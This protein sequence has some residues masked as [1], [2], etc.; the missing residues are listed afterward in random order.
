MTDE[1]LWDRS[2]DAEPDVV[3]LEGLLARYGAKPIAAPAPGSGLEPRI[4]WYAAAA[5]AAAALVVIVTRLAA[6]SDVWK[7]T[8]P[9]GTSRV[10]IGQ[11][12]RTDAVSRARLSSRAVGTVELA[13]NTTLR[14]TEVREGR[15]ILELSVGTIH[16]K[17]ISPPGV[18]VV[19]TPKARAMD[20]GCEYTLEVE[21]DGGGRLHVDAGWVGL[22]RYGWQS[23]VPERASALFDRDGNLM[24]PVF[25][26]APEGFFAAVQRFSLGEPAGEERDAALSR[27]LELARR[28]DA[29]TLLNLFS[30]ASREERLL[31]Y[32]RLS[33][34]VPAPASVPR[35]AM[36]EG[37]RIGATDAWWPPVLEASGVRA[38]KK[39]KKTL[40]PAR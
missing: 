16:A 29:L 9:R 31:V 39:G 23:L 35:A 10:A 19:D 25:D 13:E 14:V 28:R 18:F 3:R 6:P 24:P 27:I 12:V 22:T 1:Y 8:G 37:W 40:S 4:A 32:D 21:P 33:A 7:V 11:S 36:E 30:R 20:L 26:D 2:G 38:I 5:L 34:L 17:T 15:S